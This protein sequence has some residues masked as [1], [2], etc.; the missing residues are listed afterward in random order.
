MSSGD[1][2]LLVNLDSVLTQLS[3]MVSSPA[4][5]RPRYGVMTL[6]HRV[7]STDV[8]R[9]SSA[10]SAVC[11]ISYDG[12]LLHCSSRSTTISMYSRK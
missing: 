4:S 2:T 10:F 7:A 9:F 6:R 5:E 12:S 3:T 8:T 11:T 1:G